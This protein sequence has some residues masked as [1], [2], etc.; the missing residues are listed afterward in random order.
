MAWLGHE[1][2]QRIHWMHRERNSVSGSAPGGR[3]RCFLVTD[4]VTKGLTQP[5]Q[6]RN[7]PLT[8]KVFFKN[9]RRFINASEISHVVGIVIQ[10]ILVVL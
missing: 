2:T 1:S 3:K 4:P 10:V 8:A 6:P 7:V 5:A 9:S